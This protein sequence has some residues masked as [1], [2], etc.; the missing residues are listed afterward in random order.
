MTQAEQFHVKYSRKLIFTTSDY[1][2]CVGPNYYLSSSY[3]KKVALCQYRI[4]FKDGSETHVIMTHSQW[5]GLHRAALWST[6]VT[7]GG[8]GHRKFKVA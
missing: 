1:E 6:V 8:E 5:N 3:E 4:V 2:P 7:I